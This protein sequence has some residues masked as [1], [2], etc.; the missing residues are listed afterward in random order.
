MPWVALSFEV[1]ATDAEAVAEALLEAGA[2]SVDVA[3]ADAGTSRERPLLVE[4][5]AD[6]GASAWSRNRMSALFAARSGQ[7]AAVREILAAL[8]LQ[9][10]PEPSVVPVPDHDWVRVTQQQF[11][12]IRI[13]QR[14]WIVPSWSEIPDPFAINLR[15]DPGLAF[16]TGAHPTTRQCLQWLEANVQ[17]GMSVLD[18]GCGSGVLGI[19][20]KRLGAARV[21]AVDVDPDALRV[22]RANALANGVELEV[23]D[24]ERVPCASYDIVLANILAAPLKLLAPLLASLTRRG[25]RI[26]LAGILAG[27][28]EEV[29]VAYL[30]WYELACAVETEGWTCLAG[31]RTLI[32]PAARRTVEP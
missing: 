14:L 6:P 2:M 10:L 25:G 1:D 23:V 21:V 22:T 28:A 27:Q 30:P 11:A 32:G 5:G 7:Q 19:A 12:P 31:R 9:P 24:C 16:G 18:Y 8:H 15:L 13:S 20:A 17:S 4:S 3:D 26:A 29:R